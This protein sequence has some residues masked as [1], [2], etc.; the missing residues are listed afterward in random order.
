MCYLNK[1]IFL[2]CYALHSIKYIKCIMFLC[3]FFYI[4][5][6]IKWIKVLNSHNDFVGSHNNR[7][8]SFSS[9]KVEKYNLRSVCLTYSGIQL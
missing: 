5:H 3:C 6:L 2:L 7:V 4:T 8:D 9:A 1:K